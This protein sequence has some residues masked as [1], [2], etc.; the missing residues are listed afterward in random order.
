MNETVNNYVQ[1]LINALGVPNSPDE[2][3]IFNDNVCREVA[4]TLETLGPMAFES[5]IN[6]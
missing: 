3:F 2:P 5:L 1:D 4:N 6:T